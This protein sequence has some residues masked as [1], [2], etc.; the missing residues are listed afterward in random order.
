[1]KEQ[2]IEQKEPDPLSLALVSRKETNR[3]GKDYSS[4]DKR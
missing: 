3:S 4:N 1:M 2:D